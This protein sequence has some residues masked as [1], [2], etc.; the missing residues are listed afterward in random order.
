MLEYYACLEQYDMV[1]KWYDGYQF[2]NTQVYCPWDV[3]CYLAKLRIDKTKTVQ[4]QNYWIKTSSNSVVKQFIQ[5]SADAA[6]KREIERLVAGETIR[7]KIY[8]ELSYPEMYQKAEHLW[9]MLFM[10]GYLTKRGN[11]DGRS[12]ELA[13]PNLEIRDMFMEQIMEYFQEN[14]RKDGD[15]LNRFCSALQNGDAQNAEKLLATR[16][17]SILTVYISKS[18]FFKCFTL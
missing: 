7:K 2:G 6:A 11:A 9:S 13:I 8:E 17:C 14:I 10:T 16:F 12:M 5:K 18:L 1:K 4:P 15:T 3:I